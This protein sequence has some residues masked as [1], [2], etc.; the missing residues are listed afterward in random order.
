MSYECFEGLMNILKTFWENMCKFEEVLG[1][2]FE[3]TW[4]TNH[5]DDLCEVIINEFEGPD[6]EDVD[7]K[8][9]PIV[10]YWMFDMEWGN[11]TTILPHKGTNYEVKH[12][13]DLYKT[14]NIIKYNKDHEEEHK[15]KEHKEVK[16]M[17][18]GFLEER[19]L[20]IG[21]SIDIA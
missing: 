5:F 13:K 3:E 20:Q 6:V 16:D 8:I 18:K 11:K 7:P 10:M 1:V 21:G 2:R 15:E 9:G 19:Y 17:D 12:L 4:M 14:L